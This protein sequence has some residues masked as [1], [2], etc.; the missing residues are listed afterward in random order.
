MEV[1]IIRSKQREQKDRIEDAY[2]KGK[3]KYLT[4]FD[5]SEIDKVDQRTCVHTWI[6]Q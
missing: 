3:T 6:K 5:T 2:I 1:H 4:K